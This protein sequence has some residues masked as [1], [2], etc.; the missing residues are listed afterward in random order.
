MGDRRLRGHGRARPLAGGWHHHQRRRARGRDCSPQPVLAAVRLSSSTFAWTVIGCG[1]MV[2][3][4]QHA[5]CFV[6][7]L[8][9]RRKGPMIWSVAVRNESVTTELSP[10]VRASE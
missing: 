6:A 5:L 4:R 9:E 3:M 2:R 1:V 10:V 7:M 8:Q